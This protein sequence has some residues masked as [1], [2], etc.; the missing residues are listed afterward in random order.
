MRSRLSPDIDADD[1]YDR[2]RERFL[3]RTMVLALM[4][5]G[6]ATSAAA[7][8]CNNLASNNPDP[9]ITLTVTQQAS[10]GTVAKPDTTGGSS[11]IT[12]SPT[13]TRTIPPNLVINR[14]LGISGRQPQ[15]AT[16]VISGGATCDVT[17]TVISTTG[18]LQSVTLRDSV[19]GTNISSGQNNNARLN[20]TGSFTFTIGVS[21]LVTPSTTALGGS[22]SIR[23]SY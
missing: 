9:P 2:L 22:I 10:L 8:N 23:V 13:G 16:A 15:A 1:Q 12:L 18:N 3:I 11:L 6:G 4:I 17:I 7:R 5:A 19:A 20:G 14:D 21:E